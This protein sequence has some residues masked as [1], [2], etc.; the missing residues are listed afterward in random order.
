M[1][2]LTDVAEGAG[3]S[4]ST[5]SFVLNPGRTGKR[6][7]PKL[8]ARVREVARELGYV[9]NYHAQAM[10]LGRAHNIGV[11]IHAGS[12]T[13][14]VP[15]ERLGHSY[16][17]ALISGIDAAAAARGYAMTLLSST[18]EMLAAER[19][20]QALRQRRMDGIIIPASEFPP[21]AAP[22]LDAF[23]DA[24]VVLIEYEGD[25]EYAVVDWDERAGVGKAVRHLAELGHKELL[26]LGC[27]RGDMRGSPAARETLFVQS[28]WDAGLRGAS[29]HIDD[30]DDGAAKVGYEE[31]EMDSAA[32]AVA[33]L[34]RRQPSTSFT[35]VVCYNDA[36]AIGAC[37]A[38]MQAGLR[39]PQDISVLG[40][41]DVHAAFTI[42]KLTTVSHMLSEMGSRASELVVEA[43]EDPPSR[44][45]LHGCRTVIEPKLI[46]RESTGPA[47]PR[48]RKQ[49]TRHVKST[50]VVR[51]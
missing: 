39:I 20:F 9:P 10:K 14:P 23:T 29:C 45:N 49:G 40:I 34:L 8:A 16:F 47:N 22:E 21:G 3:V 2:T 27:Q 12:R 46:V 4:V 51:R 50:R 15:L 26:W 25:T 13:L 11:A 17:G 6:V 44:A 7:S 19:G 24:P 37:K 38:L 32:E 33:R 5:A 28:V 41:D 1:A 30:Y 48:R 18:P 35:A 31:W 43:I 42:P 36:V